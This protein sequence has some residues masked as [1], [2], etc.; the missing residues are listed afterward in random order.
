MAPLGLRAVEPSVGRDHASHDERRGHPAVLGRALAL[1]LL[2]FIIAFSPRAKG[3]SR[4]TSAALA[5]FALAASVSLWGE[6]LVPMWVNFP[7]HI[8]TVFVAGLV[9]PR[10]PRCGP[11]RTRQADRL[12]PLRGARGVLGGVFNA[13]VAPLLFDFV[14][15]YPIALVLVCLLR[16]E[17]ESE[18]GAHRTAISTALDVAIPA[19]IVVLTVGTSRLGLRSGG[20]QSGRAS[21]RDDRDPRIY[22]SGSGGLAP[23]F[24]IGARRVACDRRVPDQHDLER[25]PPGADVFGVSRVIREMSPG[26]RISDQQGE[27]QY[28]A[29]TFNML[30]HGATKHGS[31]NLDPGMRDI[32]TAYFHRQRTHRSNLLDLPAAGAARPRRG[33]RARRRDPR[34]LRPARRPIHLLRNRSG[35]RTDRE[36]SGYFTFLTDS[37]ADV[38]YV[39]GDG[40]RSLTRAEDGEYGMIVMDAFSSD[41]VPVHL[42]TREAV[43]M[44]FRKLRPDGLSS[45]TSRTSPSSSTT[46]CSP[47][48]PTWASKR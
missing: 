24:R 34:H 33:H 30:L 5:I 19:V 36:D 26:V 2:T 28:V 44:Y 18:P 16:P 14:A 1:Y 23:A 27:T 46:S 29:T 15:E 21:Y 22:L 31:Q 12:L 6:G 11:A 40:R 43:E 47:S 37:K 17:W 13:L 38:N 4:W 7:I 25:A 41:S 48:P 42:L 9:L 10:P 45:S 3:P 8:L 35:G 20:V 39:L 32:A